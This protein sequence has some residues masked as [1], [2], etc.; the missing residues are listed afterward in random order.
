M[1]KYLLN[2]SKV[3]KHCSD[4]TLFCNL[5]C[6]CNDRFKDFVPQGHEHVVSGH[7]SFFDS[8]LPE[9]E[10]EGILASEVEDFKRIWEFGAKFRFLPGSGA[11]YLD[12]QVRSLVFD[13]VRAGMQLYFEKFVRRYPESQPYMGQYC[14]AFLQSISSQL[15]RCEDGT[16]LSLMDL[17]HTA[18]PPNITMDKLLRIRNVI[19]RFYIVTVAD[20]VPNNFVLVCKPYYCRM[21]RQIKEGSQ[22]VLCPGGK[23]VASSD[24]L[25]GIG[26]HTLIGSDSL[27]YA[28]L[29]PKLHKPQI[30]F[31]VLTACRGIQLSQ[32]G[33]WLTA[34][35]RVL[36]PGTYQIWRAEISRGN[37]QGIG[38]DAPWFILRSSKVVSKL[39]HPLNQTGM[40]AVSFW[41]KGGAQGF[42]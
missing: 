36:L 8:L 34:I 40:S 26:A 5:P 15:N 31:R 11:G 27:A 22:Y 13:S 23:D 38:S 14:A 39:V 4:D 42:D 3:G 16:S 37:L 7:V 30:T 25:R 17:R 12:A 1:G 28:I 21:L 9:F 10:R 29:L 24:N 20:K 6:K 33:T 41:D 32:V 2:A 18:A 35:F 19:H